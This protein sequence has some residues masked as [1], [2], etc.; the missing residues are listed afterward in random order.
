MAVGWLG[1]FVNTAG[2]FLFKGIL[3]IPIIPAGLLAI[4][5]AIIHNFVWLRRWAWRDRSNG[6]HQTF[7]RQLL[8]YNVFTG[9]VDIIANLSILWF[10]S[11]FFHV[12][13]LLANVLGMIAG[14][15][16]KFWVNEKIIFKGA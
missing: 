12:H 8:L 15:F 14:P 10:L 9:A 6:F 2:L 13:Y 4:E 16:I 7:F 3:H 5:M 1:M 11:T